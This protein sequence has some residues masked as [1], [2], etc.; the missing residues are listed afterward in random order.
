MTTFACPM[1]HVRKDG[2]SQGQVR[3]PRRC[4]RAR[5]DSLAKS[6]Q[7]KNRHGSS[8]NS[9]CEVDVKD[10]FAGLALFR[11]GQGPEQARWVKTKLEAGF[12]VGMS[13]MPPMTQSCE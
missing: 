7:K 6:H 13:S 4:G 2:E 11:H 1:R 5:R 12:T 3:K 10:T 8:T 9:A